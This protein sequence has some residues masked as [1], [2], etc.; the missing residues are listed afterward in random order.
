[1]PATNII[2]TATISQIIIILSNKQIDI[3]YLEI[4]EIEENSE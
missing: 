3:S 4:S 1:M 2:N